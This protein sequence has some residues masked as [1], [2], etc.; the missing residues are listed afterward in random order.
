MKP[1]RINMTEGQIADFCQRNHIRKFAFY[2]SV[3]RDDFRPD[4]DIDI[5]VEF[6]PNQLIG[7]MAVVGMERRLSE[8]DEV[9]SNPEDIF[10]TYVNENIK[11]QEIRELLM[12]EFTT[13][14][15]PRH[16]FLLDLGVN[17]RSELKRL[18]E[19][20]GKKICN[21][22]EPPRYIQIQGFDALGILDLPEKL[23]PTARA[24]FTSDMLSPE[25]AAKITKRAQD[26]ELES[27]EELRKLGYVRKVTSI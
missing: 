5:L 18:E 23:R 27:L 7:L 16:E 1:E 25:T 24:L 19:E 3:L 22:T 8:L 6:E 15:N 12:Y 21:C 14:H 10:Q 13:S 26:M 11:D 17:P 20:T 4:S 2:G 9:Y